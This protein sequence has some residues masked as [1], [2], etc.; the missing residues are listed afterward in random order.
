MVPGSSSW[1]QN[2]YSWKTLSISGFLSALLCHFSIPREECGGC[3]WFAIEC[4][5]IEYYIFPVYRAIATTVYCYQ[6]VVIQR[7]RVP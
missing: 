5:G 4:T 1:E 3:H 2:M 6:Y 7:S